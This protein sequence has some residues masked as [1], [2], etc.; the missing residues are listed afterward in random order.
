MSACQQINKCPFII[1]WRFHTTKA[2]F[3]YSNDNIIIKIFQTFKL[4][5]NYRAIG[6]PLFSLGWS[7]ALISVI[8]LNCYQTCFWKVLQMCIFAQ[9]RNMKCDDFNFS[10]I[11]WISPFHLTTSCPTSNNLNL[12]FLWHKLKIVVM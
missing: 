4:N 5:V 7:L 2:K 6:C 12:N 9:P 8:N 11:H 10:N 3:H 1:K